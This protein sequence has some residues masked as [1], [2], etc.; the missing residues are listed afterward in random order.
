[1]AQK[2]QN[3]E[4]KGKSWHG[5][6]DPTVKSTAPEAPEESQTFDQNGPAFPNIG[7]PEPEPEQKEPEPDLSRR[8][9]ELQEQLKAQNEAAAQERQQFQSTIDKLLQSQQ[10]KP[11]EPKEPQVDF[12]NLPDPVEKPEEFQRELQARMSQTL[13]AQQQY[14]SHQAQSQYQQ[15]Q[16]LA[17]RDKALDEMWNKFQTSYSD[18]AGKEV[19]L[20]GAIQAE[21]AGYEKQG[22][23]PVDGILKD[24]DAFIERVAQRMRNEL[25]VQA[26]GTP[27]TPNRTGGIG[28]GTSYNGASSKPDASK[29]PGFLAQLKKAQ[30]DTGLI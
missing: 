14:V 15:Y 17:Q 7:E 12:S 22:L 18:L 4:A 20:R 25:G 28:A 10:P 8:L 13:Q 29:A 30:A 6:G 24:G 21:S 23:D 9:A 26:P 2:G 1:M 19:L 11:E 27:S 16:T 3:P 5:D